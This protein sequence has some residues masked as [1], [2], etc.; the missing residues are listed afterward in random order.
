MLLK[1]SVRPRVRAFYSIACCGRLL[2]LILLQVLSALLVLFATIN[3][4][5]LV[6]YFNK[7][8]TTTITVSSLTDKSNARGS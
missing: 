5:I 2:R 7:Q 3:I 8:M 6:F 1:L 4:A